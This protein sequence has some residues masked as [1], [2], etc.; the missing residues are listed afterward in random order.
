MVDIEA[1]WSV[2]IPHPTSASESAVRLIVSSIFVIQANDDI[3][4][5]M[6]IVEMLL[7]AITH[8]CIPRPSG[9]CVIVG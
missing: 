3:S 1:L 5:E 2:P 8:C 6:A 4:F 9:D 7:E